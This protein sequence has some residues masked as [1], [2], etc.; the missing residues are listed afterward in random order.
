MNDAYDKM[1]G[2]LEHAI[3]YVFNDRNLLRKAL[4]HRS[5][6]N[7]AG[8]RSVRD[9]ERLE[10][11]GDAILDFFLSDRLYRRFP[12]SSEGELTRMRASLVDEESLARLA[13][14]L[15]LGRFMRLGRGEEKSGGR[16]KKSILADSYE[17]LLAALYLDGGDAAVR[18]LVDAH[19]SPL[20]DGGAEAPVSRDYKTEFQELSQALRGETPRYVLK[21]ASGPD[22]D[23]VFRVEAML[24]SEP[25]GEG[26]G[27]SKKEA[28]QAAAREGCAMLK[29]II[30]EAD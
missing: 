25:F 18:S 3:G 20:M 27:R 6:V 17:A 19:F 10:F 30:V 23:P 5:F 26:T 4:T 9:N 29:S 24:G 16:R 28:E 12:E 14:R 1:L 7:E 13:G 22:H 15:D 21:G 8:D 11:F 2:E